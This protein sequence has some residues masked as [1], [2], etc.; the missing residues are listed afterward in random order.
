MPNAGTQKS[1]A[2]PCPRWCQAHDSDEGW[3]RVLG[4][5]VKMCRRIVEVD[6]GSQIVLERYAAIE[7]ERLIVLAPELRVLV[8]EALSL[9]D[10]RTL[11]DTLCRVTEKVTEIMVAA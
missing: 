2:P 9:V 6:G 8:D 11:A 4:E 5:T 3:E 1:I 10:A 7:D